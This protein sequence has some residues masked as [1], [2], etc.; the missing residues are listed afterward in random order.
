MKPLQAFIFCLTV[1]LVLQSVALA[2]PERRG[3]IS[4][5]GELKS[6]AT[7]QIRPPAVPEAGTTRENRLEP[8]L[9]IVPWS[10]ADRNTAEKFRQALAPVVDAIASGSKLTKA[11]AARTGR[12][13]EPHKLQDW[14][15]NA[16]TKSSQMRKLTIFVLWQSESGSASNRKNVKCPNCGSTQHEYCFRLLD[17]DKVVIEDY[18]ISDPQ[19]TCLKLKNG[20]CYPPGCCGNTGSSTG[21][22]GGG[23]LMK[24]QRTVLVFIVGGT[25][26]NYEQENQALVYTIKEGV[27]QALSSASRLVIKSKSTPR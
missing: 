11:D 16:I 9:V 20:T 13:D 1:S 8:A 19:L 6:R 10:D 12:T 18:P 5:L 22:P 7:E 24:P 26:R 25:P 14:L 2:Q 27:E 3:P 15:T 17:Y 4:R 21:G 23:R